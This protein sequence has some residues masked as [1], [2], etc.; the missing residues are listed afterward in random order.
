MQ[1]SHISAA[2]EQRH[3]DKVEGLKLFYDTFKHI[4]TLATGSLLLL[5]SLLERFFE[6]P[7]CK[8]MI[9]VTFTALV[10]SLVSALAAMLAYGSIVHTR[11]DEQRITTQAMGLLGIFGAVGGFVVGIIS[12]VIFTMKNFFQ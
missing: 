4:R 3:K 1:S 11:E 7:I 2:L 5:A 12:L 9:G 8:P 10:V 6:A